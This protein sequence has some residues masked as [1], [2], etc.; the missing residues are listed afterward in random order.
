[1]R[2]HRAEM[3]RAGI[4]FRLVRGTPPHRRTYVASFPSLLQRWI[5]M[6]GRI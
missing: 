2:R 3:D 5:I 1:M 6:R 4:L